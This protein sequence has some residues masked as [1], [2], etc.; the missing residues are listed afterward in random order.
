MP[1]SLIMRILAADTSTASGSIALLD[2]EKVLLEWV[3]AASQT[4]NRRLL[5]SIE[6]AL[7]SV[8]WDLGDVNAF[9]VTV[10][11]GSFTGLRIGLTTIKTLAWASGKAFI[12]I[13]SLDVLAAALSHSSLP[14][15]PL[16]N[17][18][19]E[20]VYGCLYHPDSAGELH[21]AGPY[22]AMPPAALVGLV[23]ERTLFCGDGWL[24]YGKVLQDQLG[25][26]AVG[27][28]APF[29]FIRAAVLGDLARKRLERGEANDPVTTVPLYV[30]PSEA[31]LKHPHLKPNLFLA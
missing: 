16:I 27:A 7:R 5:K 19:K 17:A 12:G 3:L 1:V 31:E 14:V 29:H 6:D 21:P 18:H 22:R 10:G 11:P 28:A 15:Y 9:A 13:P 25:P 23:R 20:E 26:L 30:R 24:L 2:D 8:G 4:H